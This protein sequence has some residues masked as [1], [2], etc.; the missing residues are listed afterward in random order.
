[1]D[2]RSCKLL[3]AKK[4]R[5]RSGGRH[6]WSPQR[7]SLADLN[8][9]KLREDS[10]TKLAKSF[11][12]KPHSSLASSWNTS[13]T[14]IGAVCSSNSAARARIRDPYRKRSRTLERGASRSCLPTA[15]APHGASGPAPARASA[16]AAVSA[17]LSTIRNDTASVASAEKARATACAARSPRSV[18]RPPASDPR[19]N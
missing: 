4:H 10:P 18:S 7:I 16:P 15:A 12:S 13:P 2:C 3:L 11:G 6:S 8:E 5:R 1:M 14:H 19:R 17:R 9:T